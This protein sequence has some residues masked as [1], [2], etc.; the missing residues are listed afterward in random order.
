MFI[1]HSLTALPMTLLA[2]DAEPGPSIQMPVFKP[3][4]LRM[5]PFTIS[6]GAQGPV[7]IAFRRNPI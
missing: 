1:M 6:I 3:A 2:N 4:F 5:G 7:E